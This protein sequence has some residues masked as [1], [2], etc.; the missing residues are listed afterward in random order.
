M[1]GGDVALD[2]STMPA[3]VFTDPQVATVGVTAQGVMD[4][5]I[6]VDSRVLMPGACAARLGQ[7]RHAWLHQTGGGKGRRER[8][9]R[10]PR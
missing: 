6:E 9:F 7:F 5:G 10:P 1:T 4:Q 3:V 8:S 2:V